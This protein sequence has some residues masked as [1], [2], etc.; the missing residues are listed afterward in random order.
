MLKLCKKNL[1][2]TKPTA[3][4]AASCGIQLEVSDIP[5]CLLIMI[6]DGNTVTVSQLWAGNN[7]S[8]PI[9]YLQSGILSNY[10][11]SKKGAKNI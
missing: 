9:L 1:N 4:R 3:E 6:S 8:L 5:D 7:V 10:L 2:H 11:T